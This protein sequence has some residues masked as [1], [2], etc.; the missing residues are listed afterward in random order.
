V[1]PSAC[2]DREA[3]LWWSKD[4]LHSRMQTSATA[5]EFAYNT[6]AARVPA[7]GAQ[8]LLPACRCRR[9]R[10][11][12]VSSSVAWKIDAGA[13]N[14][15]LQGLEGSS[16]RSVLVLRGWLLATGLANFLHHPVRLEATSS[17]GR[18]RRLGAARFVPLTYPPR[19][20]IGSSRSTLRDPIR[21]LLRRGLSIAALVDR[22]GAKRYASAPC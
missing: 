1:S 22:F 5:S 6:R 20:G 18:G 13:L 8:L 11:L 2:R 3:S 17:S 12:V 19:S 9:Q 15:L 10:V 7:A 16:L 21:A 4:M 14:C